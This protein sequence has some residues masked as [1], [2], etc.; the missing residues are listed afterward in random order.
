MKK[1][2]KMDQTLLS[3]KKTLPL[4][5]RPLLQ[6]GILLTKVCKIVSSAMSFQRFNQ[7]KN[8]QGL[9][10]QINM[11]EETILK[12]IKKLSTTWKNTL[13]RRL[14]VGSKHQMTLQSGHTRDHRLTRATV[15]LTKHLKG[16]LS[17]EWI[18]LTKKRLRIFLKFKMEGTDS[19]L[20]ILHLTILMTIN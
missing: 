4:M 2:W 1:I 19:N 3:Q 20:G 10:V 17:S 15:T 8:Q 9:K 14:W 11:I 18:R 12:M 13:N 7:P 5:I 16:Q 6:R